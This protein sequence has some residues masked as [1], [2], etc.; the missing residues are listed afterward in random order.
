MTPQEFQAI[1]Q[2]TLEDHHLSK[3]ERHV[4]WREPSLQIITASQE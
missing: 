1:L 3:G 4:M 2:E